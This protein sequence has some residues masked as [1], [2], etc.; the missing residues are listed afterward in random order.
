MPKP[1][2]PVDFITKSYKSA[3]DVGDPF[4]LDEC[5]VLCIRSGMEFPHWV[6]EELSVRSC[7]RLVELDRR[8]RLD[9]PKLQSLV[10]GFVQDWKPPRRSRGGPNLGKGFV[11]RLFLVQYVKA[12][13]SRG[14]RGD[15]A[16]EIA[17]FVLREHGIHYTL[18]SAKKIFEKSKLLRPI[19][20]DALDFWADDIENFVAR[21][22]KRMKLPLVR[23][24]RGRQ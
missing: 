4:A 24:R 5:V 9:H 12:A 20:E 8:I 6:Q 7:Q 14:Y 18:E 10:A 1:P 22:A 17:R 13:R 16:F 3:H 2:E 19:R 21:N 11:R 15:D 23:F